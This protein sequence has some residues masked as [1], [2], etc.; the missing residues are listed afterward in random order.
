M[1]KERKDGSMYGEHYQNLNGKV[2]AKFTLKKLTPMTLERPYLDYYEKNACISADDIINYHKHPIA[3]K[4]YAWHISDLQI[5]YEPM[6]LNRFYHSFKCRRKEGTSVLFDYD[7][8][9]LRQSTK[10][11]C[12][13]VYPL[14]RAPRS[15]CYVEEPR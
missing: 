10:F 8:E 1:E 14:N 5:F 15:W 6:E 7:C 2:V 11:G 9:A 3:S 4:L 13:Y 12:E